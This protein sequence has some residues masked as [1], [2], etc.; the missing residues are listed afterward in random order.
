MQALTVEYGG[1]SGRYVRTRDF[2]FSSIVH[3]SGFFDRSLVRSL[4]SLSSLG[5]D[6][7]YLERFLGPRFCSQLINRLLFS[8]LYQLLWVVLPLL[9]TFSSIQI[10]STDSFE[11]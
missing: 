1:R 7:Y 5:S 11:Q 3:Y 8:I 4:R 2:T 9:N 10:S 6:I